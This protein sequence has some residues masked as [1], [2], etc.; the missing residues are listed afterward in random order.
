MH[1]IYMTP[2]TQQIKRLFIHLAFWIFIFM[3]EM[4]YLMDMYTINIAISLSLFELACYITEVYINLSI[5]IPKL[6]ARG[7]TIQY[8]F[9]VFGILAFVY[10]IYIITGLGNM[11]LAKNTTRALFTFA[12]NHGLFIIISFLY[13]YVTKYE[14]ERHRTIELENQKLKSELDLLKSQLSPHFLFNTLNGIY[15]LILIDP[16]KAALLVDNLSVVLRYSIY[17]TKLKV[18]RLSEEVDVINNYLLLQKARLQNSI[19]QIKFTT[20]NTEI[21]FEI[22]PLVLLT[23]VE[24]AF[25][26]SDIFENEK[27][28]IE[29]TLNANENT[30]HM[31]V[32][33]TYEPNQ[34][35]P[36]IGLANITKQLNIAYP[37]MYELT[38]LDENQIYSINIKLLHGAA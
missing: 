37:Y 34:N 21:P 33:N 6:K 10:A 16:N 27:G 25:K 35:H 13:W 28:F 31:L 1:E 36:G 3:Y 20:T 5:L 8:A 29:I 11:L 17:S 24:N 7:K 19:P 30:I 32:K 9:A 22:P 38:I 26:H 15:S 18:V 2:N 4:D 14:K 12:I 23:I